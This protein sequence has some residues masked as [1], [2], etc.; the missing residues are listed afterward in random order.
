MAI[1]Y[2]IDY[3]CV[4]KQTLS[5]QGILERL[6]KR[7]RAETIIR[8]YRENGDDRPPSRMGFDFT[9]TTPEGEEETETIV[10]QDLLD[11]VAD[12]DP[13]AHH[14]TGCPANRRGVP[15]GCTGFVQ[16][17]ISGKAEAWLLDQLPPVNEPLVWLL[18]KQGVEN[19]SYDGRMFAQLRHGSDTYFED[20]QAAFRFLGEFSLN[21]NQVFDMIFNVG[22]IAPNHGAVLLLFFNAIERS[23]LQADAI[24]KLAPANLEKIQAHMFLHQTMPKDDRTIIEMKDFFQ[25]VWVAWALNVQLKIDA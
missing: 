17:P 1:D 3:D 12:L 23:E 14:C 10:V 16:Y 24:M 7:E 21:A 15:F 22:D 9:R 19:F 5:S 6:K 2:V 18:L 11:E 13:V 20:D 8:I 4:P 25:A